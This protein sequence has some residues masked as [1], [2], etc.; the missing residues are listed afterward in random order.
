MRLG[1][2]ARKL[3]VRPSEIVDFLADKA[4]SAEE[5]TNTK[6]TDDLVKQIVEQFA[7]DQLATI[8]KQDIVSPQE[9]VTE[10]VPEA[11]PEEIPV[12]ESVESTIPEIAVESEEADKKEEAEQIEVI[13]APKVELA[14]L[15]VLGKIDLPEPKKKV[16][17]AEDS[18][19]KSEEAEP[20][21]NIQKEKR[22]LRENKRSFPQT[23]ERRDYKPRKNPIALQREHEAREADEKRKEEARLEKEKR[24]NY[25]LQRVKASGPTKPARL[26]DEAVVEMKDLQTKK[27]PTT[28][29]GKFWRWYTS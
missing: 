6:L 5:G 14:G 27:E 17:P 23:K 11:V 8:L 21:Q 2:L 26:Y 7:P 1:Q 28:W 20:V 4:I 12:I 24:T 19:G 25:Y 18:E 29:L 16:Q 9:V 13:K 10:V 22:P 3:A 15:K